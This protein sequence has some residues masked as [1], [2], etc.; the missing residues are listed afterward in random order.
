MPHFINFLAMSL[1]K[2]GKGETSFRGANWLGEILDLENES[3]LT[4]TQGLNDLA[5][6]N[7]ELT[8]QQFQRAMAMVLNENMDDQLIF[9]ASSSGRFHMKSYLNLLR[10]E[11][12]SPAWTSRVWNPLLLNRIK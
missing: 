5:L 8:A 6:L 4:V 7:N 9:T 2:I 10:Q 12:L 11:R 3:S 1:W